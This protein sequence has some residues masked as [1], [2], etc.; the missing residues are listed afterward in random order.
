MALSDFLSAAAEF[1]YQMAPNYGLDP[2]ELYLTVVTAAALEG[3]LGE[4]PG[5]GDGGQSHGRFQFYTGGGVGTTLLNQGWSM[6]DF[7]DDRKVTQY[8]TPVLAASLI[9]QK[10]NGYT[11]GEAIRQA[12]FA[13]ERP[14]EIYSQSRFNNAIQIA[15]GYVGASVPPAGTTP[16]SGDVPYG[17]DVRGELSDAR[18]RYVDALR[19]AQA[20]PGN[21]D[22]TDA[23]ALAREEVDYY[24]SV[25]AQSSG[26]LSPEDRAQRQF[27][28]SLLL[29][30]YRN[31]ELDSAWSR[32]MDR[33][34]LA[35]RSAMGEI[36]SAA[37]S[38]KQA[39]ETT[40][41]RQES[42]TPGLIHRA[43]EPRRIIPGYEETLKKY[44]D[45]YNGQGPDQASG[46]AA[47][48]YTGG[49]GV[50]RPDP[51]QRTKD[52]FAFGLDPM[53]GLG[54]TDE[55][56]DQNQ[57]DRIRRQQLLGG[58]VDGNFTPPNPWAIAE[59][60]KYDRTPW[61]TATGPGWTQTG[62]SP[63]VREDVHES[64]NSI[65]DNLGLGAGAA[66]GLATGGPVGMLGGAAVGFG[67]DQARKRIPT[68]WTRD[69]PRF[70]W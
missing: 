39:I 4:T 37:A 7:Y 19:A 68:G 29:R 67:I 24:E 50:Q 46:G 60:P 8:W 2:D 42:S 65:L 45:R 22:L 47:G 54:I 34:D 28:N 20:E 63:L 16:S 21:L 61:G 5:V 51:Q 55:Q 9:Q 18:K 25:M 13:A 56:V 10:A 6:D 35:E 70:G 23:V 62:G 58:M 31:D 40:L 57:W 1:S 30:D 26:G 11:G 49:Q 12:I 66:V 15:A 33:Q 32:W 36:E 59:E 52:E 27:E 64:S 14:A 48:G 3:G 17:N 43:T 44:L 69:L 41:A 38:N 53:G